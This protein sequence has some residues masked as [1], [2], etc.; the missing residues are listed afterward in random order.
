[1]T[2]SSLFEQYM[3]DAAQAMSV[4]G[5]AVAATP[6][7]TTSTTTTTAAVEKAKHDKIAQFQGKIAEVKSSTKFNADQKAKLTEVFTKHVTKLKA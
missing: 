1:M 2:N 5:G 6:V 4:E 7:T 3:L